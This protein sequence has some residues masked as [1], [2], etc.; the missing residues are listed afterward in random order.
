MRAVL[1]LSV[2]TALSLCLS[3]PAEA[4]KKKDTEQVDPFYAAHKEYAG[5][6]GQKES[7]HTPFRNNIC[8]P[9]HTSTGDPKKLTGEVTPLCLSCHKER[10]EDLKK[11]HVHPP[12][13]SGDCT[14][15]H[16]PHASGHHAQLTDEIK[17]IC[18]TCHQTDD[19]PLKKAHNNITDIQID[20]TF[21]HNP[22]AT[23]NEKLILDV[24]LH[25]PFEEKMCDMCHAEPGSDGKANLRG[26]GTE[27]C[28][29]CHTERQADLEKKVVHVP[30]QLGECWICHFPHAAK[31]RKYLRDRPAVLCRTCHDWIP[32]VDHPVV[33]HPTE[34][35]G[36][37]N[38]LDLSEPFD[39]A[40]CHNPHG[41]D[42]EKLRQVDSHDFCL[43]C[44]NK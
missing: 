32:Q 21:C 35:K 11:K 30:F 20:C 3:V 4:K 31:E 29:T 23:N 37:T 17:N 16:D 12:F 14:L 7:V 1:F 40:S 2:M 36:K 25:P 41:S 24:K 8:V 44:H 15:C 38:P 13:E 42:F 34:K 33:G 5:E 6:M 28:I 27:I 22:H 26:S 18:R 10:Q 9:C 19:A 43:A 39:C